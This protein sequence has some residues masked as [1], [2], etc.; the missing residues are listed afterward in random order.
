MYYS[1]NGEIVSSTE[2]TIS[3]N[4]LGLQRGYGIFDYFKTV[5]GSPVFLEHHLDRFFRSAEMMKL[6]PPF[7]R[8]QMKHHISALLDKNGADSSGVKLTLTGGESA[9]GFTPG[10]PTLIIMQ[11][12]LALLPGLHQGIRIITYEY[13]RQMPSV[14][15][16]DYLMA[17]WLQSLIRQ[18]NAQDVLYFYNNIITECPRANIF[19]VTKDHRILTPAT[20]VLHGIIRGRLLAMEGSYTV[21][22]ATI[23]L[24]DLYQAS[25]VFITSTTKN[26][27]PVLQVDQQVINNGEPGPITRKLAEE[28]QSMIMKQLNTNQVILK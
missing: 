19:I 16:T 17:V 7:S 22:E 21:S 4:D 2:A 28:L 20:N 27:L 14:K 5:K 8:E 1:I 9:D 23:T 6:K 26:V 12:P 10:S 25:E 13:Q 3:V 18:N 11:S 15:T 24:D